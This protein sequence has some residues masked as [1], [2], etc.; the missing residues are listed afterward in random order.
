M[1]ITSFIPK[2]SAFPFKKDESSPL[3][4]KSTDILVVGSVIIF[5]LAVLV[6]GGL[7]FYTRMLKDNI[8]ELSGSLKRAQAQFESPLLGDLMR[9]GDAIEAVKNILAKHTAP[10]RAF[11]FL[12]RYTHPQCSFRSFTMSGAKIALDGQAASF[13]ALAEQSLIFKEAPE[14]AN[15][16]ISG[17]TLDDTTGQV[18]FSAAIE[19]K[20]E[21]LKYRPR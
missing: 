8:T 4:K 16:A 5:V 3:Y 14:I 11:E 19:V 10:S 2:K 21:S 18:S 12:E 17:I 20:P 7:F 1:P 13:T 9:T 6:T 15:L